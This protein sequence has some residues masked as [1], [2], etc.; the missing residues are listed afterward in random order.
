MLSIIEVRFIHEL[1]QTGQF[2]LQVFQI[3][4]LLIVLLAWDS[5]EFILLKIHYHIHI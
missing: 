3:L 1:G 2:P 5:G 4:F